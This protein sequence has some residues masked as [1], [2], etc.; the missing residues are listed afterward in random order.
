MESTLDMIASIISN[1]NTVAKTRMLL[2]FFVWEIN[3]FHP[4]ESVLVV[5]HVTV[6]N[7]VDVEGTGRCQ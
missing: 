1:K 6:A 7:S 3:V 2:F 5:V 4:N